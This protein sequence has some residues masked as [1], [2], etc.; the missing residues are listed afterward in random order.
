MTKLSANPIIEL[1]KERVVGFYTISCDYKDPEYAVK[2][3]VGNTYRQHNPFVED[4]IQGVIDHFNRLA[5]EIPHKENFVRVIADEEYVVL[6]VIHQHFQDFDIPEGI[7]LAYE[8]FSL[9]SIDVFKLDEAHKICEHWDVMQWP[10]STCKHTGQYDDQTHWEA[11][12]WPPIIEKPISSH[13]MTDGPT[14]IVDREKTEENKVLVEAFVR[15]MIAENYDQFPK[16][17][18]D[19][20]LIQHNQHMKDGVEAYIKGLKEMSEL[21][22]LHYGEFFRV[23]GEGNFVFAQSTA[24]YRGRDCTIMEIF[25][26]DEGKIVE[27]WDVF[28]EACP[29]KI[30]HSNGYCTVVTP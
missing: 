5:R 17:F 16:Y 20:K 30:A 22:G 15:D 28:W 25:R 9:V 8:E 10:P 4:N 11:E 1:N 7:E 3:F 29:E 2:R 13:F 26:V 6:H 23:I 21:R 12:G 19:G 24:N 14:E 27:H 18:R